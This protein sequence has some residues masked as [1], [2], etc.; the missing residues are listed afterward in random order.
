MP[1]DIRSHKTARKK[2]FH[3]PTLHEGYRIS[4]VARIRPSETACRCS[5]VPAL[6]RLLPIPYR[7]CASLSDAFV[8]K[9]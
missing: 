8:T 7:K 9:C 5:A 3:V 2:A 1:D 6:T 4:R